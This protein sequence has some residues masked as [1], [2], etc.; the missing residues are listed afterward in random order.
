M[1]ILLFVKFLSKFKKKNE[2]PK[3]CTNCI[4]LK[5]MIF[6]KNVRKEHYCLIVYM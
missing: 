5:K 3:F 1:K 4:I 2:S 6:W